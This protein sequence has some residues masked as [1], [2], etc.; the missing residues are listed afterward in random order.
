MDKW[1]LSRWLSYVESALKEIGLPELFMD[2][3]AC[4]KDSKQKVTNM[5]L[6]M[7][8]CKRKEYHERNT[9]SVYTA[10]TLH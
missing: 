1:K 10:K 4:G 9:R 5:F 6:L 8:E 7:S 2:P 3:L